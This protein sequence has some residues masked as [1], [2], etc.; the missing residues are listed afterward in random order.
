MKI[1]TNYDF[2]PIP[3]R[4][5]DWSAIDSDS[6]DGAEDSNCP[7]GHGAT[8][9]E[10]VNDLLQQVYDGCA[11]DNEFFEMLDEACIDEVKF[12]KSINADYQ[13]WIYLTI[14]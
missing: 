12:S 4:N 10:A 8:K 9:Q 2:P 11:N 3:V 1:E 5:M 7:H 13:T 6:Y 14:K